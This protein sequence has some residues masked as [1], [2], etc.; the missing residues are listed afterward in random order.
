MS[1][2]ARDK[3]TLIDWGVAAQP[4]PGQ[5]VSGDL[6]LVQPFEHGVLLAVVDGVGHGNE[7]TAAAQAAIA[8]LEKHAPESVIT[9]VERCHEALTKTRG[10]VM[11]LASL[12]TWEKTITWLGVGNVEGRLLRGDS[13]ASHPAESVLLRSGL[14]GFQLPAL[15]A[16]VLP[17]APGDLLIFATDGIHVGFADEVNL[18][19]KPQPIA[20]HI[21]SRHFK[22]NDDA[23]VLVAR[24][25]GVRHE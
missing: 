4:L 12:H 9:L 13:N 22:G 19:D 6:H 23:L 5:A 7:A 10:A 25:L 2:D 20:D 17:V 11:T 21:L 1:S 15:H 16:S 24:Y 8:I 18:G 3:Q 14:V